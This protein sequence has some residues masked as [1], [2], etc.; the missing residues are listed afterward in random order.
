MKREE[1]AANCESFIVASIQQN[2]AGLSSGN[3]PSAA[4]V[5]ADNTVHKVRQGIMVFNLKWYYNWNKP[6]TGNITDITRYFI[7]EN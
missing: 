7:I 5:L 2:T 3:S 6:T 1:N 4:M